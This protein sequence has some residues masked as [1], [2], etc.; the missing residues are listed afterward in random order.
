MNGTARVGGEEDG[1]K[2]D[3]NGY[4]QLDQFDQRIYMHMCMTEWGH[5]KYW[6]H[7]LKKN[8]RSYMYNCIKYVAYNLHI[9]PQRIYFFL[10][11]KNK[12]LC[13]ED[14]YILTEILGG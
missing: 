1:K 14:I 9:V 6:T 11:V 5:R 7:V 2:G 8:V 13:D 12:Y 3:G 4:V 10:T